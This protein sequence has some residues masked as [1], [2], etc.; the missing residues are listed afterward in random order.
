M[1]E[2]DLVEAILIETALIYDWI[3]VFFNSIIY[4]NI[5]IALFV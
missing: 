4:I 2:F 5:I 1:E 3:N